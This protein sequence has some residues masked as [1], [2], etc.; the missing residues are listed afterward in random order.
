MDKICRVY[1]LGCR[2]VINLQDGARLGY[3]GDVEVDIETGSVR[4]IV[5]PGRLRLFGLLGRDEDKVVRWADIEKIGADLILVR[6]DI[7]S[8]WLGT[9]RLRMKGK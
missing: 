5:I 8:E 6:A 7:E 3:V 4:S 9:G 1:D 2:E